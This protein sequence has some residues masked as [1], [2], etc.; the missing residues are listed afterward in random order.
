MPDPR[1]PAVDRVR[2]ALREHDRTAEEPSA[3]QFEGGVS[4]ARL[5]PSGDERFQRLRRELGV[6]AFG[7]NLIRL[8]P[9]QQGRIHR[10]ERQEEV[11][12]VLEG[13]LTLEVEGEPRELPRWS[14]ARVAPDVRRR[15]SNRA[16]ELLLVL[17]LGGAEPHEGRDG[18]AFTD[19]D[20]ETGA[21][22]QD[23]PLPPDLP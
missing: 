17:A 4:V 15:L 20:D 8:R 6:S 11:Y 3:P 21:P 22:P 9:R 10:H 16:D 2:E 14:L 13:T 5:D 1:E 23:I 19:W 7:L 18:T 12:V